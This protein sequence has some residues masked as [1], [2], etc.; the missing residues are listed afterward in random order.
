M[1]KKQ[2]SQ[3]KFLKLE[4]RSINK[5]I[6]DA[7]MRESPDFWKKLQVEL[8]ESKKQAEDEMGRI[9]SHIRTIEDPLLRSIM[10][11]KFIQHK[12]MWMIAMECRLSES[13]CRKVYDSHFK[14]K[15]GKKRDF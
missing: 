12:P 6:I 2:L 8:L 4:I 10:L 11:K 3:L 15:R 13:Y 1:T 7:K 9:I 14:K 5:A